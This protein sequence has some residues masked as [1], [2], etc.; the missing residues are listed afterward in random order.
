VCSSDLPRTPALTGS[1]ARPGGAFVT[2][3]L[4]GQLRGC[5]GYIES[6]MPLANVVAEVA[7]KSARQDPRF[8]P[9]TKDELEESTLEVSLLSPLQKVSDEREIRIGV[10]GL[11][12]ECRGR[13]GLLLP[14]VALENG[15]D[16]Q[17]FLRNTC[18]K[19]GLKESAWQD[20]ESTLFLF[21]AEV[22]T[23][24]HTHSK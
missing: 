2:I 3:R 10:H 24:E 12:L 19:A 1:L 22:A 18:R 23:E 7:V 13:R 21:T 16:V 5:I 6:P 15:W 17:E 14:Q 20:P 4:R 8:P 9:L 11:L